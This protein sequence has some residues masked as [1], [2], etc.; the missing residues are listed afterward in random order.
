MVI[1]NQHQFRDRLIFSLSIALL[2]GT[3]SLIFSNILPL[4]IKDYWP[5]YAGCAFLALSG[6]TGLFCLRDNINKTLRIVRITSLMVGAA[7]IAITVFLD[8]YI[9]W[10]MRF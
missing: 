3:I 8:I 9:D 1:P 10:I 5:A 2:I 4:G 7:I 6:I